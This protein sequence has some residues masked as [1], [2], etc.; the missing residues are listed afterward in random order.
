MTTVRFDW[1]LAHSPEKRIGCRTAFWALG[2]VLIAMAHDVAAQPLGSTPVWTDD[3]DQAR[4]EFGDVVSTA[5]DVKGDGYA[6][7]IVGARLFDNGLTDEGRVF[8][9]YAS[10]K[11]PSCSVSCCLLQPLIHIRAG[12]PCPEVNGEN[13][14]VLT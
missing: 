5:G 10:A 7:I 12:N 2:V 14:G 4:A 11:G 13:T 6:D 3:S 1:N 8:A 9:Y